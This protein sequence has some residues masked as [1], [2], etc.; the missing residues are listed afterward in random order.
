MHYIR[1]DEREITMSDK[2]TITDKT[3]YRSIK[4][5]FKYL[6]YDMFHE[7]YKKLWLDIDTAK[8]SR[9][10]DILSYIK[11]LKYLMNQLSAGINPYLIKDSY[12]LLTGRKLSEKKVETILVIYYSSQEESA[13][14]CATM[15]HKAI[16][17]T[18]KTKKVQYAMLLTNYVLLR[19]GYSM[20]TIFQS[21]IGKYRHAISNLKNDWTYL[22]GFIVANELFIRNS[23]L[24]IQATPLRY[25]KETFM[26]EVIKYK[27]KLINEYQI[28]NLYLYG[29]LSRKQNN[30]SSDV[31]MLIIMDDDKLA[32][33]EKVQLIASC[34][35]YLEKKLE[36]RIDLI[37]I[38]SAIKLFGTRGIGQAIKIY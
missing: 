28:K 36:I 1:H 30:L 18:I 35:K 6:K 3:I 25:T 20:I 16:Y 32:Y 15:I 5:L 29:S 31:D 9:E 7:V 8:D 23:D 19:N 14:I 12:Y 17:E 24:K 27:D 10:K 13:H 11:S 34:K 21:E 37:D 38:R 22:Y 4:F 33:F 2:I 26:K